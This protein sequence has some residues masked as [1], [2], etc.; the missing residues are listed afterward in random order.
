[1]KD[2]LNQFYNDGLATTFYL[3]PIKYLEKKIKDKKL[4]KFLSLIIKII[5]SVL[6]IAF[7]LIMFHDKWPL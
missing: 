5:Y 4:L 6:A 7:A 1:M 3:K 2:Y